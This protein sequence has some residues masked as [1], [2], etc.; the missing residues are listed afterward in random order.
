MVKSYT[1]EEVNAM[2]YT[3]LKKLI[4]KLA[5]EGYEYHG[6]PL[7]S[8]EQIAIAKEAKNDDEKLSYLRKVARHTLNLSKKSE[9]KD[10]EEQG[11]PRFNELNK[12]VKKTKTGEPDLRGI[13]KKLRKQAKE[14]GN[15]R[16]QEI[17]NDYTE[18][19]KDELIKKIM[20]AEKL[21]GQP[22]VSKP[23]IESDDSEPIKVKSKP[24]SKASPKPT[25]SKDV[26]SKASPPKAS[27]PKASPKPTS[28][29]AKSPNCGK[30]DYEDLMSKKLGDLQTILAKKGV[31]DSSLISSKKDAVDLVCQIG[32]NKEFCDSDFACS[33][34][35]VCNVSTSPG[36]C[37]DPDFV[38][39][40]A[41]VLEYK[42]K[43]I[44]GSAE[45][46]KNLKKK[47]GIKE[48]CNEDNDFY[49]SSG[50]VCDIES[51]KCIKEDKVDSSYKTFD[52]NGVK[53][54]GSKDAIKLF[55][56]KVQDP[57]FNKARKK[58]VK[59]AM[60]IS[61]QDSSNF[62]GMT[63]EKLEKFIEGYAIQE[64]EKEEPEI[65]DEEVVEEVEEI[66]PK[67]KKKKI[68]EEEED[69]ENS[70]PESDEEVVNP[71]KKKKAES[72]DDSEDEESV[73]KERARQEKINI[74][75]VQEALVEVV[76]GKKKQIE[77]FSEVQEMVLK[78]LGLVKY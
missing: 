3:E 19:D 38:K 59:K 61:S 34:D 6:K 69:S 17:M 31:E 42:G 30:Y 4:K 62:A 47:L 48:K 70:A 49:C 36:I 11:D 50:K 14:T 28:S 68:I 45:A 72:V 65:E 57:D 55:K 46:I 16:V 29:K 20:K 25:L 18:V 58:L 5:E 44:I 13:A 15:V 74:K 76:S 23:S 73:K 52:Y 35:K 1:R 53:I 56:Q 2:N 63:K 41:S 78:C 64:K 75:D 32:K 12:M 60:K 77:Q 26:S 24:A 54:V 10:E 39:K 8:A 51:N 40:S 43:Q 27:P 33:D 37:V 66:I 71:K 9:N 21:L 7:E 22:K 67:K